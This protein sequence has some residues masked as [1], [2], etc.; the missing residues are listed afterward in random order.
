MSKFFSTLGRI[1]HTCTEFG[2]Y[3]KS[4]QSRCFESGQCIDCEGGPTSKEALRDFRA[5]MH[6]RYSYFIR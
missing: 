2:N 4:V 1:G 3:F 6:S 5:M